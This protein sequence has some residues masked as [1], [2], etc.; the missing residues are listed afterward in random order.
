MGKRGGHVNEMWGLWRSAAAGTQRS[1][2]QGEEQTI[3]I[4]KDLPVWHWFSLMGA[5]TSR[6]TWTNGVMAGI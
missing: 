4:L 6:N 3:V 5:L 1:P 2:V